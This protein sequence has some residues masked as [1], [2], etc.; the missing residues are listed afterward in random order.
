MSLFSFRFDGTSDQESLC[1]PLK[2]L[3]QLLTVADR[4]RASP[5]VA[6]S[7]F[8]QKFEGSNFHGFY[9][10][11]QNADAKYAKVSTMR[12][13]PAIRYFQ[14]S[15]NCCPCLIL[16]LYKKYVPSS[17]AGWHAGMQFI[18]SSKHLG[19]SPKFHMCTYHTSSK[20]YHIHIYG[21]PYFLAMSPHLEIPPPS[22]CS[23]IF[24]PTH[25]N[26]RALKISPHGKGSTALDVCTRTLYMYVHTNRFI[27]EA[28]NTRVDLC[29]HHPQSSRP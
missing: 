7:K 25:P 14:Q 4:I 21:I 3:A 29:R 20:P 6:R 8:T 22:K 11:M 1:R 2:D 15:W 17:R 26:K 28:V 13:F 16:V 12:K 27:I 24:L 19:L 10:R 9:F 23:C 18:A 5:R